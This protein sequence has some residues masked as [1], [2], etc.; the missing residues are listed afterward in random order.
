MIWLDTMNI[1]PMQTQDRPLLKPH[2]AILLITDVR[3][4]LGVGVHVFL[5]VLF[6]GEGALAEFAFELFLVEMYLLNVSLQAEIG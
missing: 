6:V 1:L 3:L 5:Q 4:D 2:A